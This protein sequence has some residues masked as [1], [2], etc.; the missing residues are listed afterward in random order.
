[1]ARQWKKREDQGKKRE[2][3]WKK[4]EDQ[5]KKRED[6]WKKREESD[7]ANPSFK[8]T[9]AHYRR[10]FIHVAPLLGAGLRLGYA[11]RSKVQMW[12]RGTCVF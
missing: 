4:R 1:M 2:D 10:V 11:R 5:W 3:Q 7:L 6:Q 12:P 8:S 9:T